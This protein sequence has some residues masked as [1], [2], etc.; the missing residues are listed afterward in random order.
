MFTT[1]SHCHTRF[2]LTA[3]QLTA[4]QGNVRCGQCHE[5]FDAYEALEGAELAPKMTAEPEISSPEISS[6]E[7]A[8]STILPMQVEDETTPDLE[9]PLAVEDEPITSAPN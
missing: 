3:A 5:V 6:L 8:D 4:A 9:M 7:P 2:R 1:C